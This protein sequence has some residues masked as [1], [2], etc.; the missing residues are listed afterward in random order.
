MCGG[1][2]KRYQKNQKYRHK[3]GEHAAERRFDLDPCTGGLWPDGMF[4]NTPEGGI[5]R[6]APSDF[7]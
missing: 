3:Q 6:D 7:C 1:M 2:I 5:R 4:V